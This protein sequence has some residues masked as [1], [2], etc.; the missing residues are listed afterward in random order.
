MRQ[1]P[2]ILK[3]E[4]MMLK[5]Q[6][7]LGMYHLGLLTSVMSL[8]Q[9]LVKLGEPSQYQQFLPRVIDV[10]YSMV[11]DYKQTQTTKHY[12]YFG[13]PNP[14]LQIKLIGFLTHFPI[15][16]DEFQ[17]EKWEA[18]VKKLLHEQKISTPD[19]TSRTLTAKNA[20]LM[21]VFGLVVKMDT[22]IEL[23][24]SMFILSEFMSSNSKCLGKI[25]CHRLHFM[26]QAT[27]GMIQFAAPHYKKIFSIIDLPCCDRTTKI[28]I[29]EIMFVL[30]SSNMTNEIVQVLLQHLSKN[31]PHVNSVI[32]ERLLILA[33]RAID[34]S[35]QWYVEIV[36]RLL[37]ICG[38]YVP[39]SNVQRF[40]QV[41][42]GDQNL[43]EFASIM[44]TKFGC[45]VKTAPSDSF[46]LTSSLI[47]RSCGAIVADKEG[48]R[49]VKSIFLLLLLLLL[50][51]FILV[52]LNNLNVLL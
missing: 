14:W 52:L 6:Q 27:S 36:I 29:V 16:T 38:S 11:V 8:L 49:Y 31:D 50:I 41:V 18:I 23:K 28:K 17:R 1:N 42:L 25:A 48:S 13:V 7:L 3:P 10:L 46:T 37:A 26:L 30:C 9:G 45:D 35:A 24:R 15:P 21:E 40:I 51:V 44:I 33:E 32:C 47:L 12:E 22:P 20:V 5:I 43:H 2:D 34:S 39:E 19:E 4:F